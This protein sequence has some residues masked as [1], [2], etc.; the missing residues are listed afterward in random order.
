MVRVEDAVVARLEK[1]GHKF[2][3]LVD[4]DLAMDVKHNNPI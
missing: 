2:E 1:F 3:I 4:P